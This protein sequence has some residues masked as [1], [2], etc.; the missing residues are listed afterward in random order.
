MKD[1]PTAADIQCARISRGRTGKQQGTR[2]CAIVIQGQISRATDAS[3]KRQHRS[4]VLDIPGLRRP[5]TNPGVDQN[6]VIATG[7]HREGRSI[8][9]IADG[10]N[11]GR[12]R[13]DRNTIRPRVRMKHQRFNGGVRI[14]DRGI[15]AR[16]VGGEVHDGTEVGADLC[17]D[18]TSLARVPV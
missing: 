8:D 14:K 6:G 12:V 15:I 10:Q 7:H 18:S 1:Q 13:G 4:A 3:S 9:S 17:V 16:R 5:E 11:L 2:R